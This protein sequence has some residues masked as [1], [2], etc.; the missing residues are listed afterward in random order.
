M[1]APFVT[2]RRVEFRETDM[3]GIVHFSNYF[4]WMEQAEHEVWRSLGLGVLTQVDGEWIS[5]PRVRA[6]C[7]YR[8]AIRFEDILDV[9]IGLLKIGSKSLTWKVRFLHQ[10]E[11][12]A[13]GTMVTVCCLVQHGHSPVSREIPAV[14]RSRIGDLLW[15]EQRPAGS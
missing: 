1:P 9:E 11:L 6:E 15:P 7:D 12:I 3:A 2:R 5:W 10:T 13:E 14:L 8:R 4:T